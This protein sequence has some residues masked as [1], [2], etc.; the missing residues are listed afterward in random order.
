MV[1]ACPNGNKNG[2]KKWGNWSWTK[3]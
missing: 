1:F 2:N 3:P